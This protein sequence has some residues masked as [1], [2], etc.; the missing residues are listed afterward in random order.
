MRGITRFDAGNRRNMT[1]PLVAP[2]F[3]CKELLPFH[4]F[5]HCFMP[6]EGQCFSEIVLKY[7]RCSYSIKKIPLCKEH[8]FVFRCFLLYMNV[9]SILK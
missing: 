4:S 3:Y 1:R 7:I 6:L 9:L 5:Y 2:N 8:V